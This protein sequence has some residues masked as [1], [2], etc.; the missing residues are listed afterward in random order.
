MVKCEVVIQSGLDLLLCF[1]IVLQK[2]LFVKVHVCD[3]IV[4]GSLA[5]KVTLSQ[6]DDIL[7]RTIKT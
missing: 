7:I 2:N 5:R 4:C 6:K 1:F 3:N